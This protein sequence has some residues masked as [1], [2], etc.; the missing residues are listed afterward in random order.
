MFVAVY[1][2]DIL[3]TEDDLAEMNALKVFLN[4]EFRIKDLG[5]L[6]IFLGLEF[7]PVSH[8]KVTSQRRFIHEMFKEFSCENLTALSVL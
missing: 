4:A 6:N 5:P 1:V 7:I 8:G 3:M 2:E